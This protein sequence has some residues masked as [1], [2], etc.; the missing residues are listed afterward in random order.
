MD[1]QA[2]VRKVLWR[3]IPFCVVCYLLNYI[4]RVNISI[5]KLKMVEDLNAGSGG[6][7][8]RGFTEDVFA[9]G[10]G[11]FFLGYFLFELPS[12]LILER[13]GARRWIARIMI[14]WGFITMSFVFVRGV[15]SFY[16][17]RFLLGIAEAG[18]FPGMILYLSYWV[19]ERYRARAAA[20][21][22]TSTAI[23]GV[24][25]NPL[26]GWILYLTDSSPLGLHNWQWLF[27][28]EGF[29]SV[30]L[31]LVTLFYLTDKP[32]E[33]RWLSAQERNTLTAVMA[34]EHAAHHAHDKAALLDAF[35]SPHTWLLSAI[36]GMVVFG[37]YMVNF[38]TPSIIKDALKAA[39]VIEPITPAVQADLWTSLLSAIPFG[40]AAVGMVLIGRHSDKHR[41]RK[42]HIAFACALIMIGLAL[43]GFA[44]SNPGTLG[45][46]LAI[47]GLSVGAMGAFGLFGPF[48]A[49]PSQLLTGTAAAAAFAIINSLG[50]LLGGFLGPMLVPYL[51]RPNTLFL[52]AAFALLALI[53][54]LLAPIPKIPVEKSPS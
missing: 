33:A 29:P 14:S 38:F 5:A 3:L 50:N 11:I 49:L 31:G 54:M 43:A 12:N 35:T 46:V 8:I 6:T 2:V 37:F 27:L 15:W 42:L 41:E 28:S 18:F 1:E 39:H 30:I 17:L 9:I 40:A 16:A 4:D 36:Y 51:G 47:T 52:A 26:G 34:R 10:A 48:W 13:V 20:L 45:T 23:S 19:P 25:G 24:I 53:L 32:A 21:F 7:A 22:L 44:S